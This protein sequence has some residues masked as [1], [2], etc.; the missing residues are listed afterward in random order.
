[1]NPIRKSHGFTLLEVLISI[2][3]IAVIVIILSTAF[4][5]GVRAYVKGR[6][7]NRDILVTSSI[8][9]LLDRQLRSIITFDHN[10]LE[11]FAWFEGKEDELIFVTTCGPMSSQAGGLLLVF[12][13]YDSDSHLLVYGQKI[14]TSEQDVRDGVPDDV[15]REELEDLLENGWDI[16]FVHN[17]DL[18]DFKYAGN[19]DIENDPEDWPGKWSVRNSVP[20]A[21]FL[22]IGF[23]DEHNENNE[24][25]REKDLRLETRIFFPGFTELV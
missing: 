10:V 3:L 12:Y 11:N 2:T 8:E 24:Q 18:M 7:M 23:V 14:V 16:N 9:G 6:E 21:I 4:R 19:Q 5:T 13:R 15:D 22:T 25:T 1:M 20:E 17:I